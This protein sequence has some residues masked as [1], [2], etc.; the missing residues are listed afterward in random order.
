ML[1]FLFPAVA[2]VCAMAFLFCRSKEHNQVA[3]TTALGAS[4][5]HYSKRHCAAK[6]AERCAVYDISYPVFAGGDTVLTA[7]LNRSVQEYVLSAVGGN[8]ELP[9]TTALDS[10]YAQFVGMFE[11]DVINIPDMPLS[12]SMEIHDSVPFM[13]TAVATIQM[14]G[15]SFTGGAHPNPF[16]MMVSYDLQKGGKPLEITDLVSDTNAIKPILEKAYKLSKGLKETDPLSDLTYPE[17]Q[18]MPMPGSIG[19]SAEGIHFFYNAYEIAPYAVGPADVLLTW[20]QLGAWA[21]R[22]RWAGE[23]GR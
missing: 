16:G 15:Y 3:K 11:E 10:A 23:G 22:K 8:A 19:L 1:K 14:D 9:F 5:G 20:E 18:Q 6:D 2:T 4:S 17:I 21:D 7:A 13:N 12:Y